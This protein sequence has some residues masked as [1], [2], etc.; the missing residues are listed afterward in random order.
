[1]HCPRRVFQNKPN[2]C[3]IE[4]EK[5]KKNEMETILILSVFFSRS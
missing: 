2:K 1:M 4:K 5:K 3:E